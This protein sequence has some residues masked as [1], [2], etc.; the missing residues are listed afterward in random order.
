MVTNQ[1]QHIFWEGIENYEK[2]ID[3]VLDE[4][5][6]NKELISII[7]KLK[8]EDKII[9]DIGC[10]KGNLVP[11]LNNPKEIV[12][13]DFSKN[14][15]NICKNNLKE[16]KNIKYE[17]VDIFEHPSTTKGDILFS[18]NGFFPENYSQI[19]EFKKNIKN[20][21]KKNGEI[22]LILSS[23]ESFIREIQVYTQLMFKKIQ[24]EPTEKNIKTFQR[25]QLFQLN[26]HGYHNCGKRIRKYWLKEEIQE[27]FSKELEII[28]IKEI[29]FPRERY[30]F[31][32]KRYFVKLKNK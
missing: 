13:C 32:F 30:D 11:L 1:Q 10:G 19:Q 22:Y 28:E 21:I 17:L 20:S 3:S 16:Y 12:E 29:S 18:I 27:E 6:S 24:T 26:A 5:K 31:S 15:L 4:S 23:F 25:Y 7:K 2:E 8:T 9:I 14:M